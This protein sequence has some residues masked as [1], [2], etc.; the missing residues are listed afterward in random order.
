MEPRCRL[1]IS[2]EKWFDAPWVNYLKLRV[3]DGIGGNVSK[4]SAPYLVAS[5]TILIE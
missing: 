1:I 4:D 5:F 3:S 2:K